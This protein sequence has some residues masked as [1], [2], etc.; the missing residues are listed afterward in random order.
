M[1]GPAPPLAEH[2]A[3]LASKMALA[4]LMELVFQRMR[5]DKRTLGFAEIAEWCRRRNAPL[6]KTPLM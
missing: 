4:A 1:S 5:T 3:A 2:K 6:L